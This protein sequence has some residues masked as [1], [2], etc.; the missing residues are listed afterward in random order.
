[1]TGMNQSG[2]FHLQATGKRFRVKVRYANN[3]A[4]EKC[5]STD[6]YRYEPSIPSANE[7]ITAIS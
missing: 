2:L 7:K 5:M 6:E 4:H 3:D 1:M